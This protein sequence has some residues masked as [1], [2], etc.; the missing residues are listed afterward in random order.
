[1]LGSCVGT[2]SNMVTLEAIRALCGS[3]PP[4]TQS[5]A[6]GAAA[7]PAQNEAA[8]GRMRMRAWTLLSIKVRLN[9]LDVL[10]SLTTSARS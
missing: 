6:S 7:I 5:M 3:L 1:M 10:L 4:V 8:A 9:S 2:E